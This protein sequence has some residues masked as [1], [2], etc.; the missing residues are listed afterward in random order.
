MLAGWLHFRL[1]HMCCISLVDT[2]LSWVTRSVVDGVGFHGAVLFISWANLF[3][4]RPKSP[5]CYE[6]I[7]ICFARRLPHDTK[8]SDGWCCHSRVFHTKSSMGW[9]GADFSERFDRLALAQSPQGNVVFAESCSD[10]QLPF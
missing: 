6:A 5:L 8:Q 9:N 3:H 10:A 2:R 1:C 7:L 4:F